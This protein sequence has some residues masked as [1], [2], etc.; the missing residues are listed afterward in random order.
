MNFAVDGRQE[1][2]CEL[3]NNF[4]EFYTC[5]FTAITLSS[6]FF[7]T[8]IIWNVRKSLD[9]LNYLSLDLL[10]P[11]LNISQKAANNNVRTV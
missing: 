6:K 11:N 5:L 8:D 9:C 2:V 7:T 10:Y 3:S 4:T 1:L